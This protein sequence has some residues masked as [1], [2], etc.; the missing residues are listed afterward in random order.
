ML[1]YAVDQVCVGVRSR[2]SGGGGGGCAAALCTD[3]WAF[4]GFIGQKCTIIYLTLQ[5]QK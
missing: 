5:M 2:S 1:V 3:S 4:F